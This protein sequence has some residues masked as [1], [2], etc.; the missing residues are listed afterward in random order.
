MHVNDET[1]NGTGY[2][3]WCFRINGGF[4]MES[5]GWGASIATATIK[6]GDVISFYLDNPITS[7]AAAQFTR[8]NGVSYANGVVT[9]T[10]K[11][12]NQYFQGA[13]WDWII[14]DF[15]ALSGVTVQV[16]N[17]SGSVVASGTTGSDGAVSISTGTLAAGTYTVKAVGSND[18]SNITKTT[19]TATFAVQ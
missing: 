5:A 10:V 17:A 8:T 12:S 14:N 1:G 6:D 3:G 4:P 9:A 2:S 18:G 15:A 11:G 13:N 16:L 19:S 7:T